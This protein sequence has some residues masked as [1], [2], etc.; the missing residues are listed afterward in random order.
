MVSTSSAVM[1]IT[2]T[3]GSLKINDSSEALYLDNGEI[4]G[5]KRLKVPY[6]FYK[7]VNIRYQSPKLNKII[8]LNRNFA[9]SIVIVTHNNPFEKKPKKICERPVVCASIGWKKV[10]QNDPALGFTYCCEFTE[11][12]AQKMEIIPMYESVE[13]DELLD[14]RLLWYIET[15]ESLAPLGRDEFPLIRQNKPEYEIEETEND[16]S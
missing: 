12:F 15:N 3:Y 10:E 9:L 13:T 2:G 4:D 16:D 5:T 14:L 11:E 8:S 6:A 7:V 1:F